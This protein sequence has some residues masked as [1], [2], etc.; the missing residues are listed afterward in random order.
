MLTDSQPTRPSLALPGH[1]PSPGPEPAES[2][3]GSPIAQHRAYLALA[4]AA[5]AAGLLLSL[6]GCQTPAQPTYGNGMVPPP[7]TG[8]VG[9]P[10]PYGPVGAPQVSYAQTPMPGPANSWQGA[11]PNG[12]PPP[13]GPTGYPPPAAAA[14]PV[15]PPP[16]GGQ[17]PP[18]APAGSTWGWSQGQQPPAQ[19]PPPTYGSPT[20]PLQQGV[21]AQAQQLNNQAQGQANQWAGQANQQINATQQQFNNQAQAATNQFQNGVNTQAQQFN[22]QMP[23]QQTTNGSW[24]P[25]SDPNAIPPARST[26]MSVPRY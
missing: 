18:T 21:N 2:H 15:Q 6:A 4:S 3:T 20:A 19:Q 8:A 7:A 5:I 25:F 12:G 26:P 11:A 22:S 13:P 24:W 17:P 14:A 23:Q 9:Q 1:S 16:P 10:A